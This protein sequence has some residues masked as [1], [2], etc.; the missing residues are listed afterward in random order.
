MADAVE[1]GRTPAH[2]I[3]HPH[4]WPLR[5]RLTAVL[6]GLS[7]LILVSF[8]LVVGRLAS[9]RLHSDFETDLTDSA[10]AVAGQVPAARFLHKRIHIPRF[11][12]VTTPAPLVRPALPTG[13]A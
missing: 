5:W 7:C 8:A 12:E 10:Q 6:A 11:P 3:W 4:R 9:N 13:P 1:P 2:P